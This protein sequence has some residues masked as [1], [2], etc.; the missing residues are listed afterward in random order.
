[1]KLSNENVNTKRNEID[2]DI[3]MLECI[4]S[5]H[6]KMEYEVSSE[7]PD[8][9]YIS[10]DGVRFVFKNGEYGWRYVFEE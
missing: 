8:F 6:K 9:S 10:I 3:R 7:Y 4:E 1:M 5:M 2:Q